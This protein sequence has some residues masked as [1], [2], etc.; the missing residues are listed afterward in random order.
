MFMLWRCIGAAT[1][2]VALHERAVFIIFFLYAK[3]YTNSFYS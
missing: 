1:T 3:H 2:F